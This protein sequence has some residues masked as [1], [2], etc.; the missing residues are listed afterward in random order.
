MSPHLF[1]THCIVPQKVLCKL[2][3][4][5]SIICLRPTKWWWHRSATGWL[6]TEG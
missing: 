2:I 6:Q 3:T 4:Y 1:E 5:R